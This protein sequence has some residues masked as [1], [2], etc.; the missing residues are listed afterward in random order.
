MYIISTSVPETIDINHRIISSAGDTRL[1]IHFVQNVYSCI[2]SLKISPTMLDLKICFCIYRGT[3]SRLTRQTINSKYDL[4]Y[5]YYKDSYY[6][7]NIEKSIRCI[8]T[9]IQWLIVWFFNN[10]LSPY[11]DSSMQLNFKE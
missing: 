11:F 8:K 1:T 9:L 7:L 2:I 4:G 3:K 5:Q 6:K 10:L